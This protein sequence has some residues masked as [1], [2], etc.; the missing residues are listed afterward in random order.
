M[1]ITAQSPANQPSTWTARLFSSGASH[2]TDLEPRADGKG[3][4]D[5]EQGNAAC[6]P[7]EPG[8]AGAEHRPP[9]A[10]RTSEL[11]QQIDA[12]H[13]DQRQCNSA[14]EGRKPEGQKKQEKAAA[15]T[16]EKQPYRQHPGPFLLRS[17]FHIEGVR[18]QGLPEL[19]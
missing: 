11:Q 9:R 16:A 13:Q 6:A 2:G 17:Q 15:R 10:Q 8:R 5:D 7:G 12:P 4:R 18:H 3:R 19:G 14:I 1:T